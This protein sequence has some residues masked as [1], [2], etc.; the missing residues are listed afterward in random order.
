MET[1]IRPPT[2]ASGPIV[3]PI[4]INTLSAARNSGRRSS[5]P[6]P[7]TIRPEPRYAQPA[8]QPPRVL[9]PADDDSVV[10]SVELRQAD[11]V[12]ETVDLRNEDSLVGTVEL[13]D[14]EP[15]SALDQPPSAIPSSPQKPPAKPIPPVDPIAQEVRTVNIKALE[16]LA[17]RC[18][19]RMPCKCLPDT[20][21]VG[22]NLIFNIGFPDKVIW[23]A[24]LP[25]RTN[26]VRPLEDPVC[27]ECTMSMISTLKFLK[28]RSTLPVPELYGYD[29]SCTNPLGRPYI[30][31][32]KLQGTVMA[33]LQ[34]EIMESEHEGLKK[35]VEEWAGYVIELSTFQF[36]HI[37][38]LRRST[39]GSEYT[40]GQLYTPYILGCETIY[41]DKLNHGPYNSAY[42]YLLC[43]STTKRHLNDPFLPSYGG[44]IRMSLVESLIPYFVDHQFSN[45]PFVLS[46]VDLDIHNILVDLEAGKI[47]GIPNW[48]YASVVPLQSH[49]LLSETLNAEFLPRQEAVY[50]FSIAFSKIY[51]PIFEKAAG[52]AAR[53]HGLEFSTDELLDR[54]L[55]YGL[56]EKAIWYQPNE[57]FLPAL[58]MHVYDRGI[59]KQET[60]K[61]AMKQSDWAIDMVDRWQ[62]QGWDVPTKPARERPPPQNRP[63]P[64]NRPPP[65]NNQSQLNQ[66]IVQPEP[67]RMTSPLPVEEETYQEEKPQMVR[68]RSGVLKKVGTRWRE[69]R[70]EWFD[71]VH[72]R[73]KKVGK[74]FSGRRKQSEVGTSAGET[75]EKPEAKPRKTSWIQ[76]I[77]KLILE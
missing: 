47:T 41:D 52:S 12:V 72:E 24:R 26:A 77:G 42:D 58:W 8:P 16:Q 27:Q 21:L 74:I 61:E 54:S 6:I 59:S 34:N 63:M 45:G 7:I 18:R 3:A 2:G 39:A 4:D 22:N 36:P 40:I 60:L 69:G 76:V 29:V 5:L 20:E 66:E 9:H 33:D 53:E 68:Q 46:H 28:E 71:W 56:F 62:V 73:E 31:M 50:P 11:S 44:N 67:V 23:Q 19:N 25:T 14:A 64:Q 70:D 1:V 10:E 51:R 37:G 38:S 15:P 43:Q 75:Y 30:F 57:K 17:S 48:E 35:I 49:I 32:E 13:Q 55:M 65:Q